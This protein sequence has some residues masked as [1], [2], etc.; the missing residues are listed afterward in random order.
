MPAL[1]L[2]RIWQCIDFIGL[3]EWISELFQKARGN[4]SK[5]NTFQVFLKLPF[6]L[7]FGEKKGHKKTSNINLPGMPN[8][9][10]FWQSK[11]KIVIIPL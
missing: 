5:K 6:C 7:C 10:L 8:T 2:E 3:V 11:Q 1:G 4:I 9:K